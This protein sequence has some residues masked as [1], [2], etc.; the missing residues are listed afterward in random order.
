VEVFYEESSKVQSK[1]S[2]LF[3]YNLL[4]IFSIISYVVAGAWF[5]LILYIYPFGEGNLL[6]NIIITLLPFLIFIMC[7]IITG[8]L[9][10]RF[11]IDYDYTFISGEVRISKVI[12]E[13][14]RVNLLTF[15]CLDIEKIGR[16]GSTT[17]DRYESTPGI[18][19]KIFSSNEIAEDGKEFFYIVVNSN[20]KNLFVFECTETFISNVL[21]FSKRNVLEEDYNK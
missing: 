14:K 12:K 4:K 18:N 1:K 13:I 6:I 15:Q 20:G 11:Y 9:K 8:L 17:F 10:N 2:S 7:G 19:K 3:K 5:F 16:Y 21:K